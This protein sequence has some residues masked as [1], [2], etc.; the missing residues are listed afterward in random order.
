MVQY[1]ILK[2]GCEYDLWD[3]SPILSFQERTY[4]LYAVTPANVFTGGASLC[5]AFYATAT[6]AAKA[7]FSR[8]S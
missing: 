3:L 2:P 4:K 7:K 8:N 1:W 6:V 5:M